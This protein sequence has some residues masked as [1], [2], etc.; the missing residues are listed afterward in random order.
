[1]ALVGEQSILVPGCS[2]TK[3]GHIG[4]QLFQALKD[5]AF[6]HTWFKLFHTLLKSHLPDLIFSLFAKEPGHDGLL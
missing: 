2:I 3:C 5:I 4:K 1:M 6:N